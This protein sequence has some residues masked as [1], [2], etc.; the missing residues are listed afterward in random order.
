MKSPE[1]FT[2]YEGKTTQKLIA[3]ELGADDSFV[4]FQRQLHTAQQLVNESLRK[5][6][7]P[8]PFAE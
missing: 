7:S 3:E 4:I 8:S 2:I 6:R 5:A 1:N